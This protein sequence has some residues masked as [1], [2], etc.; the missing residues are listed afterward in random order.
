[1]PGEEILSSKWN[2]LC[3]SSLHVYHEQSKPE[4]NDLSINICSFRNKMVDNFRCII[5]TNL[6]TLHVSGRRFIILLL[7][8]TDRAFKLNQRQN[9]FIFHVIARRS[10]MRNYVNVYFI[11]VIDHLFFSILLFTFEN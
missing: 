8:Y 7:T 6:R 4:K 9:L 10:Q 2:Y 11:V 5:R 3:F 1:M